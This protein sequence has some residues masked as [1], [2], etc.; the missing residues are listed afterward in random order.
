MIY[1]RYKEINYRAIFE[2]EQA[3]A[4]RK[5][6]NGDEM[7]FFSLTEKETKKLTEMDPF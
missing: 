6:K 1:N 5:K 4:T 2:Y 3:I 7:N